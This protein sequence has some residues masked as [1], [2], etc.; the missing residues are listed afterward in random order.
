[1]FYS[2]KMLLIYLHKVYFW[3][4]AYRCLLISLC[5]LSDFLSSEGI[6]GR[7][8]TPF[9]LQ[10][11]NELT[12]GKSLQASILWKPLNLSEVTIGNTSVENVRCRKEYG[13][14]NIK[15]YQL[16]R[17]NRGLLP[18]SPW[19]VMFKD[20]ALIHNNAKVGSQIACALSKQMNEKRSKSQAQHPGKPP[21][22]SEVVSIKNVCVYIFNILIKNESNKD[23]HS[24]TGCYRR[25]KCWFY[26]QR[27]NK[28]TSCKRHDTHLSRIPPNSGGK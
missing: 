28:N 8:V 5:R 19:H 18:Y 10:K 2:N 26:C 9:I 17:S 21:N 16:S 13:L 27:E 1:M 25:N 12:Q 20:I 24:C 11:V 15:D 23:L 3:F 14:K 7:D 22:V 4:P 6:T